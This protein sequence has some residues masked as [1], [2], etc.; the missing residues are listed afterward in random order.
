MDSSLSQVDG[1]GLV[2]PFYFSA[3]GTADFGSRILS[4]DDFMSVY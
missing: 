4:N 3:E 1:L 2:P